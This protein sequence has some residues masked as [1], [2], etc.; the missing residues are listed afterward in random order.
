MGLY[1]VASAR[2]AFFEKTPIRDIF[3]D[4]DKNK[5]EIAKLNRKEKKLADQQNYNLEK[6]QAEIEKIRQKR[7]ALEENANIFFKGGKY[8]KAAV[9]YKK[10]AESTIYGLDETATLDEILAAI[11]EQY[12]DHFKAFMEISDKKEQKRILKYVP[13][14]LEKP[15]KIA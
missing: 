12:K 15:L 7:M 2:A 4:I 5:K 14:Y 6:N 11:P 1:K 9:A 3:K 10:K 13:E 8:T